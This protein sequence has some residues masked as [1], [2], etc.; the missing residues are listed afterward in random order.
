MH[1]T[2]PQEQHKSCMDHHPCMYLSLNPYGRINLTMQIRQ[3]AHLIYIHAIM[4]DRQTNLKN[5][6]VN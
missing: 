6:K 2:F 5:V 3:R 4:A 1:D